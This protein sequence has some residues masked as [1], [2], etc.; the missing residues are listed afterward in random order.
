MKWVIED[1]VP[2]AELGYRAIVEEDG[3]V[4]CH[5]SPMG[6]TGTRLIAAAPELAA[7]L[8]ECIE[9]IEQMR[10]MFDDQDGAIQACLARAEA[11]LDKAA[12]GAS[13]N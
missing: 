6:D 4:V 10:G 3:A 11:A 2:G 9:Q 13:C 5:P 7:A 1:N 8:V 12:G